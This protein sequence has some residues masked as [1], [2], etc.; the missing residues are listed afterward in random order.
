[1]EA[2]AIMANLVSNVLFLSELNGYLW[3]VYQ[4]HS[5][6]LSNVLF[7]VTLQCTKDAQMIVVVARDA[8]LPH[9]DLPSVSFLG[10][11]PMCEAV[12]VTSAFAIYQFPLTACG[13]LLM[14]NVATHL[15]VQF[16]CHSFLSSRDK[17]LNTMSIYCRRSPALLSMRTGCPPYLKSL[18]DPTE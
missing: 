3:G 4:E 9:I 11:E 12:G 8:T 14:V 17:N 2:C 6:L 18:W 15:T 16:D 1:M 10:D 5:S 7:T 13:T